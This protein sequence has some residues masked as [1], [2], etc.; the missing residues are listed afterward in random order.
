LLYSAYV[1]CDEF[2][3][4][5]WQIKLDELNAIFGSPEVTAAAAALERDVQ[6]IGITLL[7]PWSRRFISRPGADGGIIEV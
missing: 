5:R 1:V 4:F 7:F 2:R 3:T 6:T